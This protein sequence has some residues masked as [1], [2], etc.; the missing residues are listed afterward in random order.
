MA[1]GFESKS[2]ADQQESALQRQLERSEAP[3]E[4]D[5]ARAARRR[6][7]ELGRIDVEQKLRTATAPAHRKL[8]ERTLEAIVAELRELS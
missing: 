6:Q 8:L 4:I 1:R 5:P 3:A 7:L 2:V